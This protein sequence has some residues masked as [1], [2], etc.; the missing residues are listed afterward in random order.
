MSNFLDK[1]LH[2]NIKLILCKSLTNCHSDDGKGLNYHDFTT[3]TGLCLKVTYAIYA[4][5]IPVRLENLVV[6]EYG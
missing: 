4:E 3:P 5:C 6:V 2:N 1:E